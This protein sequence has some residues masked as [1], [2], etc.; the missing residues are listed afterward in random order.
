M[1]YPIVMQFLTEHQI[2]FDGQNET[3]KRFKLTFADALNSRYD[4]E[5]ESIK[6]VQH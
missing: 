4:P 2:V 1:V 6:I 3:V 5:N